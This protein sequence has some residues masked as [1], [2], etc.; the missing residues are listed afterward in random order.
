M[1]YSVTTLSLILAGSLAAGDS[2]DVIPAGWRAGPPV[3]TP[4]ES[5]FDARAVKDPTVV[6]HEGRWHV[7]YTACGSERLGIAYVSAP[8]WK[9]L[10]A[11]P[12]TLLEQLSGGVE[13]YAAAPQVFYFAPQETWYLV[14]QTTDAN[15]QSVYATTKTLTAPQSW[16]PPAPLA[17]KFEDDKW[18]DF[19]MICDDTTAYLFYTRNHR[20]V[21]VQTTPLDA[22]PEGFGNPRKVFGLVHEAVHIYKPLDREGYHMLYEV[23]TDDGYRKFGLATAPRLEGPWL[24]RT[25]D[26]ATSSNCSWPENAAPW[27]DNVSHGE[28]L[29]TG[30]DQRLEYDPLNTKLL[31]QGRRGSEKDK[32]Y[33]SLTWSLGFLTPIFR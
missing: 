17:E 1:M 20:D 8:T 23:R 2:A 26:Y 12:R 27:T 11:A 14:F 25:P 19:W 10:D 24:D 5:S 18:I 4:R 22:F 21:Y 6:R 13:N 30:Y 32:S 31:I 28:F 16:S 9:E 33:R 7:F 3:L 29:R 15:Y